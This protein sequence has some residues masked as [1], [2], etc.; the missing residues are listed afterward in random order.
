MR[1]SGC[2]RVTAVVRSR[3]YSTHV[4]LNLGSPVVGLSRPGAVEIGMDNKRRCARRTVCSVP[5]LLA[6]FELIRED[7]CRQ[8]EVSQRER[9]T[10]VSHQASRWRDKPAAAPLGTQPRLH[11]APAGWPR[12]PSARP[13]PRRRPWCS[14]TWS[15]RV[16]AA[17]RRIATAPPL[18]FGTHLM[19][20]CT[21]LGMT[22]TALVKS[23]MP[24]MV[25][26]KHC[27]HAQVYI[28][29]AWRLA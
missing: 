26:E 29:W 9:E 20:P 3:E 24:R 27:Y 5:S 19:S 23:W 18:M 10:C 4:N 7:S 2:W 11:G 15:T 17:H 12:R 22:D 25:V 6:C 14:S 13:S 28:A 16:R 21:L 1:N 8:R